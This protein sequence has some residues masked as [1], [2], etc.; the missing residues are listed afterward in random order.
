MARK[1]VRMAGYSGWLDT[2]DGWILR[3]AGYSGWLDT[4]DTSVP[5]LK[6]S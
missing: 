1:A 4:I 3:M 2:P 5:H 6:N